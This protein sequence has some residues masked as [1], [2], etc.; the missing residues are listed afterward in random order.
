MPGMPGPVADE[1]EG[2]LAFLAQQRDLVKTAAYGL[3]DEQ[4]R[5]TPSASALSVGGLVKHVAAMERGWMDTV[6][7][8]ERLS[9]EEAAASYGD[10]M[11]M[12]P[13]ETLAGLLADLDRAGAETEAV[14]AGIADLGQAVPVPD[15]PWFPKDVAAW[16]V[17]FV[18]LHLI[19][20]LARHAGHADIIRE[21]VDGAT[22]YALMGAR[23]GF[24]A[25][26]WITPWEPPG[27]AAGS[28][29]A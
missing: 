22:W 20:E 15:E 6:I 26:G 3:T 10:D 4:A 13:D 18:L 9:A 29:A 2:L 12:G 5:A 19:E 24:T 25:G 11:V 16:S 28:S 21:H 27:D 17:R 8:R 1:R 23:E 7:Q 14:I